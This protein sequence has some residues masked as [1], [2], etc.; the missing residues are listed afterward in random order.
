MR[1]VKLWTGKMK[2]LS[3][4]AAEEIVKA[5]LGRMV[6]RETW[7]N[8]VKEEAEKQVHRSEDYTIILEEGEKQ[9]A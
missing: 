2:N 5:G 4:G 8:W 9:C 7:E 6:S 1:Y 3:D